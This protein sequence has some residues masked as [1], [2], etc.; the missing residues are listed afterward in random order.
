MLLLMTIFRREFDSAGDRTQRACCA[1]ALH[2]QVTCFSCWISNSRS[3]APIPLLIMLFRREFDSAGERTQRACYT[4]ALRFQ[5][6]SLSLWGWR[7]RILIM[8]FRE[9]FVSA[10]DETHWVCCWGRAT[11][12][13]CA[14][15]VSVCGARAYADARRRARTNLCRA[16]VNN[17]TQPCVARA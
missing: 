8:I 17:K 13:G 5:L 7:W 12:E 1:A 15:T 2:F 10:S 16:A 3:G 9:G 6:N 14:L 11:G 4:A